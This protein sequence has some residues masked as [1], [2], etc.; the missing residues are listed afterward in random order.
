MLITNT[1]NSELH[2]YNNEGEEI[3]TIDESGVI[4]PDIGSGGTEVVANPI[5]QSSG[6]LYSLGIGGAKYGIPDIPI[7]LIE[8]TSDWLDPDSPDGLDVHALETS[9][10]IVLHHL[11]GT[12]RYWGIVVHYATDMSR[13]ATIGNI[14]LGYNATYNVIK[15]ELSQ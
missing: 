8:V 13:I 5:G 3:V 10:L 9:N 2:V 6:I 4:K 12:E 14:Q 15:A 7:T 1:P 11:S